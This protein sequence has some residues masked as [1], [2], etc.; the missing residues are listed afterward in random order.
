MIWLS[1]G[2][3][4]LKNKIG[5]NTYLL[6]ENNKKVV[7]TEKQNKNYYMY[8]LKYAYCVKHSAYVVSVGLVQPAMFLHVPICSNL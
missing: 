6:R 5:K 8:D 3:V 4:F 2:L 1:E 7:L